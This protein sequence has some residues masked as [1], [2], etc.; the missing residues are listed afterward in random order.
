MKRRDIKIVALDLDG[1][2]LDDQKRLSQKNEDAL[3][4]CLAQGI[5]IVPTTGRTWDGIPDQIR[6]LP[7]LRYAITT[8][9][10]MVEDIVEHKI[11]RECKLTNEQ[12]LMLAALGDSFGAMYDAYIDGRGITESRFF[13]HLQDYGLPVEIQALV[14]ITRDVVPDICEYVRASKKPSEKVNYFFKDLKAR[15]RARQALAEYEDVVVSSSV[16]N[17]LEIN[18]SGATKGNAIWVLADYLGIDRSQTL[19][20]GDGENDITMIRQAGIGVAMQNASE[21][22]RQL[23]DYVT[24]TNNEDGVADAI[25]RFVFAAWEQERGE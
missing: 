19:A 11:I 12:T 22:L 18:A 17:N 14:K 5:H 1:T 15:E 16:Y 20:C 23:A 8:N 2:L 25:R 21:E 7:G 10:A 4:R 6:S 13:E 3:R 24:L 9:G